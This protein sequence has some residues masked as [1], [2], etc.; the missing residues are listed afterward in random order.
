MVFISDIVIQHNDANIFI[1]NFSSFLYGPTTRSSAIR[2]L[3]AHTPQSDPASLHIHLMHELMQRFELRF[4]FLSG[5]L[6][7]FFFFHSI[8][9]FAAI[10]LRVNLVGCGIFNDRTKCI[11]KR[12]IYGSVADNLHKYVYLIGR[13]SFDGELC[14]Y[15]VWV[16]HLL[17]IEIGMRGMGTNSF[18]LSFHCARVCCR[19]DDKQIG[20]KFID[21]TTGL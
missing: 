8:F 14:T 13:R 5:I 7:R 20:H 3:R 10:V 12:S 9:L 19:N 17:L 18:R 16:F 6:N 1:A 15:Y 4:F 2:I 11:F 21:T